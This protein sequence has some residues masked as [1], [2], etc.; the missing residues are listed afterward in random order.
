MKNEYKDAL[1][2]LSKIEKKKKKLYDQIKKLNEYKS[3]IQDCLVPLKRKNEMKKNEELYPH[4]KNLDINHFDA[5]LIY[6]RLIVEEPLSYAD[7]KKIT[8][9]SPSGGN[10][11]LAIMRLRRAIEEKELE[12]NHP[13]LKIISGSK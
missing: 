10:L 1:S 11:D 8:K 9:S 6:Y 3:I 4:F 13:L 5:C 2:S 12:D 7:I